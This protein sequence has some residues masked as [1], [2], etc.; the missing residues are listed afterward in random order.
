MGEGLTRQKLSKEE[1]HY[2]VQR[3]LEREAEKRRKLK[4]A[5]IEYSFPGYVGLLAQT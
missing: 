1:K 4:E 5:G 2:K 3:L